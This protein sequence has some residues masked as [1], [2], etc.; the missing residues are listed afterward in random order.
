MTQGTVAFLFPLQK[1][2]PKAFS[3]LKSYLPHKQEGEPL[4]L[5]RTVP[6]LFTLFRQNQKKLK[7]ASLPL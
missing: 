7:V 4:T 6:G 5:P 1:N 2:V 3:L